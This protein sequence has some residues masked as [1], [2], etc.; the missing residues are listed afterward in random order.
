MTTP[1]LP[2][3]KSIDTLTSP[4]SISLWNVRNKG[5]VNNGDTTFRNSGTQGSALSKNVPMFHG[6]SGGVNA[7]KPMNNWAKFTTERHSSTLATPYGNY[8]P[9]NYPQTYIFNG[10]PTANWGLQSTGVESVN[11]SG[12][13]RVVLVD[14]P[15]QPLTSLGQFMHM[16]PAYF[17]AYGGFSLEPF[18][19]MFTGGSV[20]PP[21]IDAAATYKQYKGMG[22]ADDSFLINQKL[23]DGYFLSTVPPAS[24]GGLNPEKWKVF[25][26]KND[27]LELVDTSETF[28]NS[29]MVVNTAKA[30]PIQM[31]DLRDMDK[32][33]DNLLLNGAFNVNSTSVAAWKALLY[34]LSGN[35]LKL[36]DATARVEGNFTGLNCPIPRFWSATSN[37]VPNS[38]WCAVRDLTDLQVTELATKIV[39]QVK[40]R[41]PFLS[42]GDFL[43]RRLGTN[44]ALTRVGALQAAIDTTSPDI[45]ITAKA[46]G[47]T[48]T[49]LQQFITALPSGND[50]WQMANAVD[51]AGT[52]WNTALGI[53]GY[54]MQQD[55][56]Q[57]FSP[58]MA[59]RSDTFVIRTYGET[60]NPTT[61]TTASKAYCEAVVQ[62]LPDFVDQ[63]DPSTTALGNATPLT[64]LSA[65]STNSTFGRRFKV[66]QFRWLTENDL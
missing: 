59:A 39:K 3:A 25:C 5:L 57:A 14:I 43:N 27:G 19:S 44:S 20:I 1:A 48:V 17:A 50:A 58:V 52:T 10:R 23:F 35:E 13:T 37:S 28:L 62:R 60:I 31:S 46:A 15:L 54:L 33:A 2:T 22:C 42:M 29:R 56:I 45:N 26:D 16:Q 55:L 36:W 51:G 49:N 47:Q 41:G 40:L 38:A 53:P 61:R 8:P 11:P 66:V 32:A 63:N 34:S 18:G 7:L 6:N 24:F 9:T 64:S 21:N 30:S 65:G 4:Q 12:P